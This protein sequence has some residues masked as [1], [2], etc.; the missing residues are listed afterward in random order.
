MG[1][2]ISRMIQYHKK[3]SFLSTGIIQEMKERQG[4][5]LIFI[6]RN[7]EIEKCALLH[8]IRQMR[9]EI[10]SRKERRTPPTESDRR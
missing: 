4:S 5:K 6:K 10:I 9:E 3:S 8:K 1:M 2:I 7:E